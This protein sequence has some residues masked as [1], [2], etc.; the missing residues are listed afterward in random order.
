MELTKTEILEELGAVFK[1]YEESRKSK[2]SLIIGL[3]TPADHEV[4]GMLAA[5]FQ[6]KLEK[7]NEILNYLLNLVVEDIKK[8]KST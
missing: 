7:S 8:E 3:T 1:F 4:V 5:R 2:T 6:E